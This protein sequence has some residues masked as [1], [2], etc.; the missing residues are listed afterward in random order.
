MIALVLGG[1][2]SGKSAV[3][4]RLAADLA[5]GGPVTVLAT[6]VVGDDDRAARVAAH[7]ARR[8]ALEAAT[9][10]GSHKAWSWGGTAPRTAIA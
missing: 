3:G 6:A 10:P 4:E 8:P 7:R 5:G 1:A 2:R 9:K